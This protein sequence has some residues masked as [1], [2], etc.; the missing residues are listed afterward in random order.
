MSSGT[1]SNP[2][3]G[4]AVVTKGPS[5]EMTSGAGPNGNLSY[6]QMKL[7]LYWEYYTC[8]NYGARTVTATG[9][10]ALGQVEKD[11]VIRQQAI[12]PGYYDAQ[13]AST[14]VELQKPIAGYYLGRVIVNRFTSLLFSKKRHPKLTS[15][16]PK[17]E[18]WLKGFTDAVKFWARAVELRNYGGGMGAVG[19][20]FKFINGMPRIEVHNPNWSEPTD[21]NR[22]TGEVGKFEIRYQYVKEV[23]NRKG[24]WEDRW[25]WYR[26]IIDAEHDIVW[27]KVEVTD[28]EPEWENETPTSQVDHNFGFCPVVWIQ[29]KPNSED[30]DG[31]PDCHGIWDKIEAIDHLDSRA[32]VATLANCDPTPIVSSD[33]DFDEIRTGHKE[34]I[35][36]EKGGSV[37]FAEIRGQGITTAITLAERFED[38]ALTISRCQLDKDKGGAPKTATEVEHQYS[39]MI[40]EADILRAQ[41]GI[42]IEKLMKMVLQAARM[43]LEAHPET[44][45]KGETVRVSRKIILPKRADKNPDTGA[46]TYSERELGEGEQIELKWPE[47]FEPT[48]TD[49]QAAVNAA[50]Q[51]MKMFGLIDQETA[52]GYVAP[53]FQVKSLIEMLKK[54]KEEKDI[55]G[56]GFDPPPLPIATPAA[57]AGGASPGAAATKA[58]GAAKPVAAVRALPFAKRA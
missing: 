13:G 4:G 20:S 51:A 35:Q 17:T 27:A 30:I 39:S 44:N 43:L 21:Y 11:Q 7:K 55:P 49:V 41:Y 34:A 31:D 38:Q 47:Y 52:S 29:N 14:P 15:D 56:T 16:D 2:G 24:E 26:R 1:V 12:P 53:Y 42:G 58:G 37:N 54:V 36:V 32:Y 45:D 19:L 40:E 50:G 48:Q 28:Q 8:D 33:L 9:R 22:E 5:P 10:P 23:R 57:G 46:V 25:F 3:Q 18:D 6:R